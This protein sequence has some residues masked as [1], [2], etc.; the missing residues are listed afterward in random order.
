MTTT[1]DYQNHVIDF[2]IITGL[3]RL[4]EVKQLFLE[5]SQSL[6]IDLAFQDFETEFKTLPGKYAPP[7]GALILALVD[8]REAGCIAFRKISEGICE[9]K[10]L[11][12]RDEYRCLGIGK[13]LITIMLEEAKKIG[14]QYVR[15][16]TLP[17]MKMAQ[18]LYMKFGFYD[19]E[20]YVYNPIKGTRFMEL[21]LRAYF[22]YIG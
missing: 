16:D 12:V 10:R 4:E 21:K 1:V 11:Y 15:L 6:D 20:P 18:A 13:K 2:K 3:D 8:G 19:I 9:M 5:Y 14:Y 17:T 22:D 7:D